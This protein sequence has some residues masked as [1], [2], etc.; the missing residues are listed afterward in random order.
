MWFIQPRKDYVA[1]MPWKHLDE[2]TVMSWQIRVRDY[3]TGI[4]NNT[5][6]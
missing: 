1:E 5:F 3:D 6:F 4:A 2:P